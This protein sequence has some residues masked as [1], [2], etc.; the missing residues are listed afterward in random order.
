MCPICIFVETVKK[1]NLWEKTAVDKSAWIKAWDSIIVE[2]GSKMVFFV[3][4]AH[5]FFRTTG[6]QLQLFNIN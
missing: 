2:V 4:L 3:G 1:L 6:F 5:F